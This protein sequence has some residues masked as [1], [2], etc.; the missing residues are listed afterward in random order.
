MR[1]PKTGKKECCYH[2]ADGSKRQEEG[3]GVN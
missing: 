2:R 3:M 1:A